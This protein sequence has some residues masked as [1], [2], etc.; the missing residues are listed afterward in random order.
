MSEHLIDAIDDVLPQTQCRQCGYNGCRNYAWAIAMGEAPINRCAP[1]G[2]K[3]IEALAKVTGHEV[4]ALDPEYGHEVPLELAHINP[5]TCIGCRKCVVGCPTNAI[6]G[7]PKRLHGVISDWCTGCALCVTACPVD[8]IDMR[9]ASFEWTHEKALKARR[10]YR[11]KLQR[12]KKREAERN[13][14][15]SAQSA[16]DKKKALLADIL[17]R[18]KK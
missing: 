13:A 12:E 6:V 17:S 8:C 10:L 11:E 3:G 2:Q 16:A 7:A 5:D 14:K 4:I 15:L 9:L 18:V 1:G